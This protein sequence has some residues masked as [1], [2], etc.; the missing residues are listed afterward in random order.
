MRR[1]AIQ[2]VL[3]V[4]W[5]LQ[6]SRDPSLSESEWLPG[7]RFAQLT[8]DL[9]FFFVPHSLYFGD[10]EAEARLSPLA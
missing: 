10:V 7:C 1:F 3:L 4:L 9:T 6:I 2:A 5:E 8:V